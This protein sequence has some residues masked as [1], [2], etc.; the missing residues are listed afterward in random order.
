VHNAVGFP[1]SRAYLYEMTRPPTSQKRVSTSTMRVGCSR[2]S[3]PAGNSSS[4]CSS[5]IPSAL[6]PTRSGCPPPA[7]KRG[8]RTASNG[9]GAAGRVSRAP[10]HLIDVS[11]HALRAVEGAAAQPDGLQPALEHAPAIG[12]GGTIFT[13]MRF[14]DQSPGRDELGYDVPPVAAE[15]LA[16]RHAAPPRPDD[17]AAPLALAPTGMPAS[18]SRQS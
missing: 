12:R 16:H 2:L 3:L 10:C 7:Q 4:R 9:S 15:R 5:S 18:M 13:V 6:T 17:R 8:I 1:S 14:R 11:R